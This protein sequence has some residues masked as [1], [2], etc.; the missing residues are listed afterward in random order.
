MD[1]ISKVVVFSKKLEALKVLPSKKI[2][3]IC[4]GGIKCNWENRKEYDEPYFYTSK[5]MFGSLTT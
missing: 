1:G 5:L 3:Q 2:D 4:F